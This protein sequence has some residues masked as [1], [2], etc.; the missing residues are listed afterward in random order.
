MDERDIILIHQLMG[1][2]GHAVDHP[3]QSLL[4]LVFTEDAVIDATPC[5]QQVYEGLATISAW[6][7]L[8]KPP[9][10][11]AHHMT[12]PVVYEQDGEVRVRSKF[13]FVR[14]STG[15]MVTGDYED[16]VVRTAA[17]WRIKRRTMLPRFPTDFP[18]TKTIAD[19]AR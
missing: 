15:A 9:H 1:L 16:V 19:F 3:D 17:G 4:P 6:F 7:G 12:N 10:P 8:G 13:F 11:P 2:Y 14:A 5:G 18:K